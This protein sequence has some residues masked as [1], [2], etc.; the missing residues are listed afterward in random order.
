[1][2]FLWHPDTIFWQRFRGA[3]FGFEAG[4]SGHRRTV[5]LH[6]GTTCC[7]NPHEPG[8]VQFRSWEDGHRQGLIDRE[9]L[10][11]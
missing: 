8:S 1:M 10:E 11:D 5:R 2:V 9:S 3:I 7:D 6:S 4:A